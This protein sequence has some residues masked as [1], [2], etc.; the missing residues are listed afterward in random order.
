VNQDTKLHKK[1][2][3]KYFSLKKEEVTGEQRN[4]GAYYQKNL[5]F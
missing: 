5:F 4:D 3:S 1:K 2:K